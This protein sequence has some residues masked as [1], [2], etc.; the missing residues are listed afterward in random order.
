MLALTAVAAASQLWAVMSIAS[1]L[2]GVLGSLFF[3][4][5]VLGRPGGPL[6]WLLRLSM[7]T[8]LSVGIVTVLFALAFALQGTLGFQRSRL[9]LTQVA[10]YSALLGM[11][12]GLF[13]GVPAGGLGHRVVLSLRDAAVGFVLGACTLGFWQL[14]QRADMFPIRIGAGGLAAAAGAVLWRYTGRHRT[15]AGA[16]ALHSPAVGG[17]IGAVAG[18]ALAFG[19]LFAATF[20]SG[21]P[22]ADIAGRVAIF[23]LTVGVPAGVFTGGLTQY[24]FWW[25]NSLPEKGMEVL[26]LTLILMAFLAQIA[27]PLTQVL[28]L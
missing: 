21:A 24:T 22:P 5:D 7:P 12:S 2:F 25:A 8:P 9:I 19:I 20:P 17:I 3:A 26:G 15:P 16:Q 28:G 13:V 14:L 10:L 6:R 11:Y 27:Q 23:A 18:W 4:Y 1:A